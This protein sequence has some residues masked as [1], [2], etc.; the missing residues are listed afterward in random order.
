MQELKTE[1]IKNFKQSFEGEFYQDYMRRTIY[2][3]DASPYQEKP[4]A[5]AIP[6]NDEDLK[7]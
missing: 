2:A 1:T 5:I 7:S 3:N 4:I 6:K